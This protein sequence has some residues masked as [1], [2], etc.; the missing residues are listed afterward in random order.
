MGDVARHGNAM[1]HL[2]GGHDGAAHA[3]DGRD[4]RFALETHETGQRDR[5]QDAEDHDDDDQFD[6]REAGLDFAIH[7]LTPL[8]KRD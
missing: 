5:G 2:R 6:Q 1:R 8:E 3:L 4:A 7:D